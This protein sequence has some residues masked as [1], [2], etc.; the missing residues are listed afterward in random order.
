MRPSPGYT[1]PTTAIPP[2]FRPQRERVLAILARWER[3]TRL[4]AAGSVMP[5]LIPAG[6][7]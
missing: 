1:G 2:R 4:A 5:R 6:P 7:R 3:S